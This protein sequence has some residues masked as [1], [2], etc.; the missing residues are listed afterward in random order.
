MLCTDALENLYDALKQVLQGVVLVLERS[1][2]P[3]NLWLALEWR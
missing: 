1:L 2:V 3:N